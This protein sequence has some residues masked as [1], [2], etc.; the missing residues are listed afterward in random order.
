MRMEAL[1]KPFLDVIPYVAYSL[2]GIAK[3]LASKKA[4][5]LEE[6]T[7]SRVAVKLLKR[8]IKQHLPNSERKLQQ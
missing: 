1:H 4:A 5:F 3:A 7:V 8:T 2:F 6:F